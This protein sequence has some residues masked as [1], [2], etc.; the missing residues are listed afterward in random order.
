LIEDGVTECNQ[1]AVEMRVSPG[2]ISKLAKKAMKEGWLRKKGREYELVEDGN[3][4]N[5]DD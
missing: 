5:E 3:K 4:G 2:T 1:L